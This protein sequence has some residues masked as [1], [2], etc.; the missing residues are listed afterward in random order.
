MSWTF[1]FFPS[2]SISFGFLSGIFFP[3]QTIL[4]RIYQSLKKISYWFSFRLRM[5]FLHHSTFLMLVDVLGFF[6]NFIIILFSK[7]WISVFIYN[8]FFLCFLD[9]LLF[10]LYL[11]DYFYSFIFINVTLFKYIFLF[12]IKICKHKLFFLF[13]NI[14]VH[15]WALLI[16]YNTVLIMVI[17]LMKC[18]FT[19]LIWTNCCIRERFSYI[20]LVLISSSIVLWPENNEYIHSTFWNVLT[21]FWA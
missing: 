13:I 4:C 12:I 5:S 11:L 6:F 10:F 9:I 19:F 17:L 2:L 20:F 18:N 1:Y 7:L 16:D 8:I 15:F 14:N 21:F 3:T